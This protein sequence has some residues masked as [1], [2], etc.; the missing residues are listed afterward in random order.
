MLRT[1]AAP[2][3]SALILAR[4]WFAKAARTRPRKRCDIGVNAA[5]A[6]N[7][8]RE[9]G[10]TVAALGAS[11]HVHRTAPVLGACGAVGRRDKPEDDKGKAS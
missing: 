5:A 9:H 7:P 4:D 8:S 10:G 3:G 11:G 6:R 1:A 2:S